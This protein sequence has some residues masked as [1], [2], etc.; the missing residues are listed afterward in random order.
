MTDDANLRLGIDATQVPPAIKSLDD[1]TKAGARA[2]AQNAS[3]AASQTALNNAIKAGQPVTSEMIRA[4]GGYAEAEKLMAAAAKEAAAA[5]AAS[6]V[7]ATGAAA[8]VEALGG[9]A[10]LAA[11]GLDVASHA[12]AGVTREALVMLRELGRGD[13]SRMAGSA[14]I[15][16]QRLGLLEAIMS[17]VGLAII[18]A[19]GAVV[20][21]A[22][23]MEQGEKEISQFNNAITATGGYA[24]LT[25]SQFEDMAKQIADATG[26]TIGSTKAG[27]Q[28]VVASGKLTGDAIGY[29][30]DAAQR[31]S[32]LTGE[33]V[34]KILADY[35]N[36]KGGVVAWA[37]KHQDVYHD[38]TVDQMTHIQNLEKE[39]RNSE[40]VALAMKDI[41][42]AV[43]QR[44][45]PAYGLLQNALHATEGFASRMWDALLGIGRPKTPEQQIQD[46]ANQISALQNQPLSASGRAGGGQAG[47]DANLANLRAQLASL[48]NQKSADD[49][50]TAADAKAAQERSDAINK[51]FGPGSHKAAPHDTTD[52]RTSQVDAALDQAKAAELQAQSQLTGDLQHRADLEKQ[53]LA[54]AGAAKD[55]QTSRLIAQ[56]EA[57]KG[58]TA[59]TKQA[60]VSKLG[61]VKAIDDRVTADKQLLAQQ[62]AESAI[63]AQAISQRDQLAGYAQQEAQARAS[64]A[65]S[66]V[67]ANRIELAALDQR[68]QLEARDLRE[69][70][71]QELS[72]GKITQTFHDQAIAGQAAAAEAERQATVAKEQS[73]LVQENLRNT[74]ATINADKDLLESSLSL[75]R[76]SIERRQLQVQILEKE[77]QQFEATNQATLSDPTSSMGSIVDAVVNLSHAG[78]LFGD[79]LTLLTRDAALIDFQDMNSSV[80]SFVSAIKS[81][82]WGT[83]FM[84][85]EQSFTQL[86]TAF[87]SA[88]TAADKI[89]AVAGIANQIGNAV[90][91]KAGSAISGAAGGAV[92]GTEILPGIG[93]AIGAVVGGLAG[94]FGGGGDSATKQA[95]QQA[96][97]AENQRV[98]TAHDQAASLS[99][100]LLQAQG[101]AT[102]ALN[103]QREQE[104]A[105]LDASNQAMAREVYAAQDAQE[106]K[107]AQDQADIQIMT[108]QGNAAGALAKQ[109]QVE[110]AAMDES[111]QPIQKAIYAAQDAKT[112]NDNLTAA[113]QLQV[114]LLTA[115][116]NATASLALQRKLELAAMDESLRPI[117]QAVYAY[118]DLAT[119]QADLD[120]AHQNTLDAQAALVQARQNE[121]ASLT[122][123]A[124]TVQATI[125]KF[126]GFADALKTFQAQ[127]SNTALGGGSL[128]SQYSGAKTAFMS[129]ASAALGDPNDPATQAA[130]GQ[131]ATNGQAFLDL[132]KQNDTTSLQYARDTSLVKIAVAKAA[133]YA[134]Q[135]VDEGKQQ[136][137]AL[138]AQIAGLGA[139]NQ[140]VLSVADAVANLAAANAAE[141]TATQAVATAQAT[142]QA[143]SDQA[144]VALVAAAQQAAASAAAAA[145]AAAAAQSAGSQPATSTASTSPDYAGYVEQNPDLKTYYD[146][147]A[148]TLAKMGYGTEAAYGQFNYTTF[149]Q[150]GHTALPHFANGGAFMVGGSGG[151]D[152]QLV[153]F[154][155]SPWEKVTVTNPGQSVNDNGAVV[156]AIQALQRDVRRQATATEDLKTLWRR[157][158][159]DGDS[160]LTTAA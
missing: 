83:A 63:L 35:E 28:Q 60:L 133:T 55:A 71:D 147:N 30:V 23:A 15:L 2:E 39:G 40:A 94:L 107:D 98:Q 12:S 33:N 24:G 154:K 20:G 159:R 25:G 67:E 68:Q 73:K 11:K 43:K 135:Q 126:Q 91:G 38:L 36:M 92:L 62:N 112:A 85:L 119:A 149:G 79:K 110:L 1:L 48:V 127:L 26:A 100:Q 96:Q 16:T 17:P 113:Q 90:G 134:S 95:Q 44:A 93:T 13:F 148:A 34:T 77:R 123:T 136:L 118:Q 99:I 53:A 121:A 5:H 116:G 97:Q 6:S 3:L 141:A 131:I 151:T 56:I 47:V 10:A 65:T 120:T 72:Q 58:L 46:T 76:T 102:E 75:A 41:D 137:A 155:A 54:E 104:I 31:Y 143:A 84:A 150:G 69:R 45:L 114:K 27:L 132:A 144:N 101:N 29:A 81:H 18:A 140:S 50:K 49:A 19:T 9:K 158:T 32:Q 125:D 115:Q 64:M 122:A 109:R 86:K 139:I 157:V 52:Q 14:T 103:Q 61:Q 130:Y 108:L 156:A 152:S 7:A 142:A 128:R 160:L 129:T 57:D 22:Y 4:V 117:Q 105:K 37:V 82:D 88:G 74:L 89:S 153:Q 146:A 87:S 51:Q 111:L 106:L 21:L 145:T 70:L 80:G 124:S 66:A 8:T 138:N 78:K 42:D 59:A